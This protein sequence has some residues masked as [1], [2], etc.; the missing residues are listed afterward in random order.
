MPEDRNRI[1]AIRVHHEYIRTGGQA[2]AEQNLAIAELLE[3]NRFALIGRDD[4]PYQIV[5]CTTG[6]KLVIH[7]IDINGVPIISHIMSFSPLKRVM[8]NYSTICT[9][10]GHATAHADPY[11][12]Q[13]LDMTR[14]AIHNEASELLR[15]RLSSKVDI[16]LDTARRLFTL[17]VASHRIPHD[18]GETGHLPHYNS[19]SNNTI[20]E[21]R[22]A[23]CS[24]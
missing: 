5:L 15:E 4:G 16:D 17:I 2:E 12:L 8:R 10:H 7:V 22:S 21:E 3:E 18:L 1:C 6:S 9:A 24:R 11:R 13:V 20:T 23:N 14:R 19:V